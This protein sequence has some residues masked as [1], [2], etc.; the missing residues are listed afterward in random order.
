ML[1][2]ELLCWFKPFCELKWGIEKVFDKNWN[3][4]RLEVEAEQRSLEELHLMLQYLGEYKKEDLFWGSEFDLKKCLLQFPH[5]F[6]YLPSE[7]ID[8][9]FRPY[10]MKLKSR[11]ESELVIAHYPKAA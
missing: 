8:R 7:K 11:S 3:E 2:L 1:L 5:R 10:L 9:K 4:L 6:F